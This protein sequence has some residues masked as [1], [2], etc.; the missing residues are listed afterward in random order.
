MTDA[1]TPDSLRPGDLVGPWR[2]EGYAGR[3]TY[4][5]VFRAR[6]AG[7]PGSVPVALKVALF[8]YDPRFLREV[9]LL[10]RVRHPAVPE[11][12]DRGWWTIDEGRVHPYLVMQWVNGLPLY[13]WARVHNPTCRQVLQV[14]AQVAWALEVLH[15]TEGI[16]RDVKG[17][18]ILVEPEGRAFLMDF[19]SGT[20][21]GAPPLTESLMPPGTREYRGPEALRFQWHHLRQREVHYEARTFDDLY[22]LGVSLYRL[23]TGVYPPP[24][25]DP[26]ARLAPIRPL[27]PPP[28]REPPQQLNARVVPELA[29]LIER[30]LAAIPE[31]R[32]LARDVALA[33][34]SAAEHAGPEA[35]VPLFEPMRPAA[36]TVRA[37]VLVAATPRVSAAGQGQAPAPA[38][39]VPVLARAETHAD[40]TGAMLGCLTVL[41]VPITIV[42]VLC[43]GRGPHTETPTIAQAEKPD[44]GEGRDAGTTGVGDTSLTSQVT[45]IDI[46]N[47][48]EPIATDMPDE[49]L[50]GQMRAPCRRRGAIEI[51]GG[52]W[53]RWTDLAPPCGED[54]YEWKKTC[55]WPILESKRT[56]TSKKRQ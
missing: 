52:C 54:A 18:N 24:G 36:A 41:L 14:L 21:A 13:E 25:T 35:D 8:A 42:F 31:E 11:L 22:A 49:P 50:P 17:D 48:T 38:V 3:G 39:S 26:E 6:R 12:L 15:T 37:P 4:G 53:I 27:L 9:G 55:Y 10:S 16:H 1:L 43:I 46:P 51:N 30:M 7:H 2:I 5:V 23:V 28:P 19:G 32:G 40:D 20:W 56:P 33:A 44:A 45:S 47:S 29:A 34:E